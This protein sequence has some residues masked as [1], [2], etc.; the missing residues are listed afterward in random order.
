MYHGLDVGAVPQISFIE[1][2]AKID[3]GKLL[4]IHHM[5]TFDVTSCTVF[6]WDKLSEPESGMEHPERNG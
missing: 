1:V 5:M 3:C 2:L 6:R 4:W